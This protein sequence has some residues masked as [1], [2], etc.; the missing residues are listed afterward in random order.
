MASGTNQAASAVAVSPVMRTGLPNSHI[1]SGVGPLVSCLKLVGV[2]KP[3]GKTSGKLR[4]VTWNVGSNE[5]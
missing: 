3:R 1:A 2:S 5:R 4:V